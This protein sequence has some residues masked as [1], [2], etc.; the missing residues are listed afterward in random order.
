VS[1]EGLRGVGKTTTSQRLAATTFMLDRPANAALFEAD[2][3][4]AVEG[5]PSPVLLDEWQ[6]VPSVWDAVRRSVD[7]DPTAGRFLLCGSSRATVQAAR[8]SGAG[9]IASIE[10]RPMTLSERS[11]AAPGVSL[12][13][14]L[15]HG[16]DVLPGPQVAYSTA[17]QRALTE[18]AGLPGLLHLDDSAHAMQLEAYLRSVLSADPQLIDGVDRSASRLWRYIT[19]YA[20]CVGTNTAHSTIYNA[21]GLSNATAADY[22][23]VL[24]RLG[25][26]LELPAFWSNTLKSLA[27]APKRHLADAALAAAPIARAHRDHGRLWENVVV[28]QL[29]AVAEATVD[30][31]TL[32]H[33]RTANG[34]QEVDLLISDHSGSIVA[35]EAKLGSTVDASDTKHLRWLRDRVPEVACGIVV[36][37][38]ERCVQLGDGIA[39]VPLAAIA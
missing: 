10:M 17:A 2:A 21:A 33:L 12:N 18:R 23:D 4:A 34:R 29:R 36:H 38:G 26:I 14:L 9:R 28:A 22:H 30:R 5:H 6:S 19:A 13:A 25:L 8:H 15:E 31:P 37:P 1:V 3:F 39:A 16:T 7:R 11:G 24:S 20:A 35:V 32:T 27:K